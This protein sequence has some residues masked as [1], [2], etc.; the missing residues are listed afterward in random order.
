MFVLN[1]SSMLSVSSNPMIL[2]SMLGPVSVSLY[3][4]AVKLIG[5]FS[6]IVLTLTQ[7]LHPIATNFHITKSISNLQ[8]TLIR[9]PRLTLLVGIPLCVI[10]GGFS[11]P[12]CKIWLQ[13]TLSDQYKTVSAVL[14]ISAY[15][16][17]LTFA[18]SAQWPV[19]LGMDRFGFVVLTKLPSAV[20]NLLASIYLV[21]FTPLG[22]VGVVVPTLVIETIR[23]P[24]LI[25]YTARVVKMRTC[26]Y[27][28]QGFFRPVVVGIIL[29]I[30]VY[31]FHLILPLDKFVF[32]AGACIGVTFVWCVLCWYIGFDKSDRTDMSNILI[33]CAKKIQVKRPC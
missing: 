5:T 23:R 22:V 11:F 27:F 31:I 16:S 19:L 9:G 6:P 10:L 4:P 30:P 2:T 17:L 12:I 3:N 14:L 15:I 21:G 32:L 26:D 24:I 8:N 33:K 28:L 25:W 1:L 13:G 29:L 7:Q 20:I 18:G